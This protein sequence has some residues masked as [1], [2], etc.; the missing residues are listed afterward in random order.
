MVSLISYA[1]RLAGD[2]KGLHTLLEGDL[3]SQVLGYRDR[4]PVTG[5]LS[6]LGSLRSI[7]ADFANDFSWYKAGS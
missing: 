7:T 6:T 5:I 1:D 3:Q 2:L 4:L